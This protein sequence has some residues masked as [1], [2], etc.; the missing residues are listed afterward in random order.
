MPSLFDIVAVHSDRDPSR[1]ALISERDGT[2]TYGELT[3]RAAAFAVGL[4]EQLGRQIAEGTPA[5]VWA[6]PAVMEAY[7]GEAK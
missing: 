1:L 6:N 2:R 5:E 3:H 4:R 7:L